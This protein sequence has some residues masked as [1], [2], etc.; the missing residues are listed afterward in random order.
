M[1]F[2]DTNVFL[3]WLLG[4]KESKECEKIFRQIEEEKIEAVCSVFSVYSICIYLS[5]AGKTGAA[6][7]LLMFML[8]LENLHIRGTS[9]EDNLKVL[10]LAGQKKLDFDDALQYYTAKETG[11]ESIVTLDS[12]F[13]K[14][15]I[16]TLTP[17]EV[18]FP[19]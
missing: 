3:E 18:A 6:K 15:G 7:K 8:S 9:L 11:C 16:K 14:A 12:D 1:L 13:R 2:I 10:D 17:S 4:R 19:N 5:D